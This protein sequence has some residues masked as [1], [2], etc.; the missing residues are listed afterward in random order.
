MKF[1]PTRRLIGS[2]FAA[3]LLS[4]A[5]LL[6]AHAVTSLTFS[7]DMATNIANS[8][9][10]PG[11]DTVYCQGTFNNW[12][13]FLQLFQRG[14]SSVFTNTADNTGEAGG[15]VTKY[16]FVRRNGGTDTYET[17]ADFNLRAAVLPTSG[18]LILPTPFFN[19]A[20]APVTANVKFSV[21]MSQQ[22][23]LGIFTNGSSSVEVRGNFNGWTGG[24]TVLT[25]NP[26]VLRTNQYGLVTANVYTNTVACTASTNAA[27]DYKYVIT[28]G[29]FT[30]WDAP[31]AVSSDNGGNRFFVNNVSKSLPVVDF[32]DQPFAPISQVRL[33]VDMSAVLVTDPSY[34]PNSVVLAGSFNGWSADVACTNNPS[35]SNT[36]IYSTV[37]PI[38]AGSSINY[39]FRYN[40]GSTQYDHAPT[41]GDRSYT[42]QVIPNTNLPVVFFNNVTLGDLLNVDTVVTFSVSMTNAVGT[43]AHTFDPNN[44][45]V[46]INGDF[47]GWVAWT[48]IALSGAGLTCGNNPP[49]SQVYTY[50]KTFLK[51]QSRHVQYKYSINGVDNEAGSGQDH[52][53]YIRSTNGVFAMPLDTFGTQYLEPKFGNLAISRAVAGALPITWLGYPGVNLQSRTSLSTG[54]WADVPN[55]DSR[56]STNWPNSGGA[57]FFRL[58]QP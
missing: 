46:F 33:S 11:T 47:A 17:S 6:P 16:Q 5:S 51:N 39:Q 43:D 14:S 38:G 3:A 56:S 27:M 31:S 23:A 42:A 20:G 29:G 36:N 45:L 1:R 9:F 53:R 22:I 48:P 15:P 12:S 32:S 10:T 21:D 24:A 28:Y 44:D 7:V 37:L 34:N 55:T 52:G 35:A 41:G 26:S 19:D 54:S 49:G 2:T 57:R 25:L 58:I 50:Q 18:S 4:A 30:G 40:N 8:T 13:P